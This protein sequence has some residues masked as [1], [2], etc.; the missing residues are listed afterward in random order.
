MPSRE[1]LGSPAQL[2]V[3]VQTS[4][5]DLMPAELMPAELMPAELMPAESQV[6]QLLYKLHKFLFILKIML[7]R[8]RLLNSSVLQFLPNR[9]RIRV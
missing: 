2:R 8:R 4:S 1:T 6:L 5:S 9:A 7:E 3:L